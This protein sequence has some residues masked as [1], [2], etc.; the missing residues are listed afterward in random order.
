[1]R[2]DDPRLDDQKASYVMAEEAARELETDTTVS[3][4]DADVKSRPEAAVKGITP[5]Q[6]AP[7]SQPRP[8]RTE[9]ASVQSA[10]SG[11]FFGFIKKLFSASPAVEEKPAPSNH[12]GRNQGRNGDR[13]RGRNR[14][15]ERSGDRAERPAANAAEGAPAE[16]NNNRNGNRNNRNGNRNAG[17]QN[18]PKPERQANPAPVTPATEAVPSSDATASADGEERR[19]RGRNRRGRGRGQRE[20][21]ERTENGD[22]S[23]TAAVA[24]P[25]A[26]AFSGPPVG[27]AGASASMP[28]Q[29][30]VNS[31]GNAKKQERSERA[32]RAPRQ[33]N[34]P[35]Q[36]SAPAPVAVAASASSIEVIAKPMPELPKVAFQ[37]L[38]EI[39][40]HSVVQSAGMIW[41]ATDASKHAEAQNQIQAEPVSHNLGRTP[42]PAAT[43]PDGPMVLVET[44]GQEKTV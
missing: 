42:K 21:G 11:G 33:S 9:K 22:A 7:I 29:N 30:I 8:A 43:L 31:F 12:R 5:T 17:N 39:P 38:E 35:A 19:G 20:R 10:S 16:G 36:N 23:N 13:N 41:V 25:S 14:R 34:R 24:A 2:H 6:P 15:G 18:G 3:R 44:G 4:K 1:L 27:M 32:P 28:L 40:L 26:S 37:A